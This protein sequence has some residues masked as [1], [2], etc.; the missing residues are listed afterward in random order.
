MIK[1]E[2]NPRWVKAKQGMLM[3][4]LLFGADAAQADYFNADTMFKAVMK[5]GKR[6]YREY[7]K[8]SRGNSNTSTPDTSEK[9]SEAAQNPTKR[10]VG[11][12][13]LKY[14]V[15]QTLLFSKENCDEVI[16]DKAWRSCYINDDKIS[17]MIYYKLYGDDLR[18]GYI[19][20]RPRFYEDRRIPKNAR[21]YYNSYKN[22]HFDRGHARSHASTAY[23]KE[24]LYKTYSMVNIWPQRPSVNRKT[25]IK[26]EK[27]E[28]LIARKLGSV[29]VY[30]IAD[31]LGNTIHIGRENILVP[32]GF[33]KV[34][35]NKE[36]NF[37]ECFYYR[38]VE[39]D[40]SGDKLK[41]H[42]V[43][44]DKVYY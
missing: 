29:E 7:A 41:Q 40:P 34:I 39:V 5:E 6:Q 35:I 44:C 24:L 42:V 1:K 16:N 8:E 14:P 38:N 43:D 36:Q 11:G 2:N 9:S 20:E 33:Y 3:F 37:R 28:R 27:Y 13:R 31:T 19:K 26:A 21:A 10:T 12:L 23:D 15:N 4:A 30:N 22:S 18:K 17:S 32:V 25:W